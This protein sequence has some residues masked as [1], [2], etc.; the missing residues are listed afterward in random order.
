M[1]ADDEPGDAE[2]RV[3]RRD[4][5][6]RT[7]LELIAERGYRRASLA[8]V[9]ARLGMSAPG[10]LH[11]FPSKDA[12][13]MA[14]L[15]ERSRQSRA[16][17]ETAAPGRNDTDVLLTWLAGTVA[18]NSAEPL[19]TQLHTI[20][21]ADSIT[22]GHPA[23]EMMRERYREARGRVADNIAADEARP[24]LAAQAEPLAALILAAMDGLQLQWLLDPRAVDMSASFGLLREAVLALGA[25][26]SEPRDR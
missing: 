1:S 22:E 14:V 11:Y 23:Q 18:R 21:S 19:L 12:L 4:E 24:H 17:A 5:V 20:V 2:G 26:T 7:A 25:A 9:A 3:N 13:L 16:L 10:V 6:V 8:Q 15:A